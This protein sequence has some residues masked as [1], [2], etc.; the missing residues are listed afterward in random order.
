MNWDFYFREPTRREL[1]RQNIRD[2]GGVPDSNF[3]PNPDLAST[4][5]MMTVWQRVHGAATGGS[6]GGKHGSAL[7]S[8]KALPDGKVLVGVRARATTR[9]PRRPT[10]RSR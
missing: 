1:L 9:S 4:Q 10:S 5:A 3:F 6:A 2:I 8:V 7:G